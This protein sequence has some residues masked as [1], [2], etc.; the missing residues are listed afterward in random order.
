MPSTPDDDRSNVP[1]EKK[2]AQIRQLK[3]KMERFPKNSLLGPEESCNLN[4][5]L[6]SSNM[7]SKESSDEYF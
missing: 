1:V 4:K 7:Q 6:V 3:K 5:A 2:T